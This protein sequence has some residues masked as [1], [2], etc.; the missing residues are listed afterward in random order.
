MLRQ[1]LELLKLLL[2]REGV[3]AQ[4]G[5]FEKATLQSALKVASGKK[6][7]IEVAIEVLRNSGGKEDQVGVLEIINSKSLAELLFDGTLKLTWS[8]ESNLLKL[9]ESI[10]LEIDP[11]STSTEFKKG[12]VVEKTEYTPQEYRM[13]QCKTARDLLLDLAAHQLCRSFLEQETRDWTVKRRLA[14]TKGE[15]EGIFPISVDELRLGHSTLKPRKKIK[16]ALKNAL[17]G[18][19]GLPDLLEMLLNN[20]G[21]YKYFFEENFLTQDPAIR[22]YCQTRIL[23]ACLFYLQ[24]YKESEKYIEL[25]K[26]FKLALEGYEI[27]QSTQ[28]AS[29]ESLDMSLETR[30]GVLQRVTEQLLPK[31]KAVVEKYPQL[32]RLHQSYSEGVKK[33]KQQRRS[34]I[35][36][37]ANPINAMA[38]GTPPT[39][40]AEPLLAYEAVD[41][42]A[43]LQM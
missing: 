10:E 33:M 37:T 15:D 41:P 1:E 28:T 5:S 21:V 34:H 19:N 30:L 14:M 38:F 22:F 16:Q 11:S 40:P 17:E 9:I 32:H 43:K 23:E 4:L 2:N 8:E 12:K 35:S 3:E 13:S 29:G 36:E 25:H 27:K 42:S 39:A 26:V 7:T 24:R 6:A 20:K 18:H 31:E